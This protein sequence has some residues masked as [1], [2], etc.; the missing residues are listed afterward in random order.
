MKMPVCHCLR[1]TPKRTHSTHA[2]CVKGGWG[3]M[4]PCSSPPQHSVQSRQ[5]ATT[6]TWKGT[7][8]LSIIMQPGSALPKS[9]P[10]AL[11]RGEQAWPVALCSKKH[12]Q[13]QSHSAIQNTYRNTLQPCTPVLQPY[14]PVQHRNQHVE[15]KATPPQYGTRH[16]VPPTHAQVYIMLGEH[17]TRHST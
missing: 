15:C 9:T 5:Q 10:K 12:Q 16:T 11:P 13:A 4:Q 8:P 3:C 2:W 14:A 6:K 17:T 1:L 7:G